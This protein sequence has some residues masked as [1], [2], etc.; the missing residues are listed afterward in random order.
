MCSAVIR[1]RLDRRPAPAQ[2][3]R[4]RRRFRGHDDIVFDEPRVV[5]ADDDPVI[6]VHGEAWVY[7]DEHPSAWL[8]VA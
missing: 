1:I 4:S 6:T 2:P 8:D 7:L 3:I 5:T